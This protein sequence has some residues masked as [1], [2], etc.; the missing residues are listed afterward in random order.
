M[1]VDLPIVLVVAKS[2]SEEGP[3]PT[4]FAAC[5][6]NLYSVHPARLSKDISVSSVVPVLVKDLVASSN[7]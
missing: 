1:F 6:E 3:F 4:S 2:V 7:M 5:T